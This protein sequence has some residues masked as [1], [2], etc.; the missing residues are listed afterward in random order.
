[1]S[2]R[3]RRTKTVFDAA[4]ALADAG[5]DGFRPG[6]VAAH[7]REAGTPI[8]AWEVRGELA[9]LERF[10]LVALD[11]ETAVW[12][13][14]AGATF[15]IEAAKAADGDGRKEDGHVPH[16]REVKARVARVAGVDR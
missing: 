3:A 15:S 6:D 10:G 9:N 14:I 16:L 5:K 12:R 13:L 4:K 7:L 1:M 8:D 2:E 11:E